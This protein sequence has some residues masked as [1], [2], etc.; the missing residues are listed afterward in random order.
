[1]RP[2]L[3]FSA[4]IAPLRRLGLL[5][6]TLFPLAGCGGQFWSFPEQV[7]GNRVDEEQIA[8][9]VV[10]TSTRQDAT[11][12]IGSPTAKAAFDDNTW[13][14][15]SEITRPVIAGTNGVQ[16]Q[17]VYVLSFDPKGVL[18]GIE[19]RTQSDSL[20]V[21]VV[22]RTTPSPG[23]E[24]SV[25]QQLLGNIGRYNPGALANPSTTGQQG[26]ATNPGNF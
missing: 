17:L 1:M 20:P 23:T 5:A 15:A 12:L 9:L 11:A 22:E 13:I 25:L 10:G 2:R 24:A 7:R 4:P 6:A 19:K 3:H 21:N 26:S 16:D 8:Q 18:T 14:Y